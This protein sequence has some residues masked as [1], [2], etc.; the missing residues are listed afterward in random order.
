MIGKGTT[1]LIP[2]EQLFTGKD[3]TFT[4]EQDNSN[5]RHDLARF[6]KRS[7]V[8]SRSLERVDISLLLL[9]HL[10]DPEGAVSYQKHSYLSSVKCLLFYTLNLDRE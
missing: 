8:T 1:V 3:L 9:Y 7:K 4:I 6:R 2:E 5:I 10:R